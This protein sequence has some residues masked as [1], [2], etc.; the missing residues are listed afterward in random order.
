MI[1][2]NHGTAA[3]HPPADPGIQHHRRPFIVIAPE[4]ATIVSRIQNALGCSKD[5]AT[6]YAKA[7]GENPEIVHGKILLRNE[8]N[9]IVAYVPAT[10]LEVTA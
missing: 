5:M 1:R 7:I 2:C 6:E 8:Q 3:D 10:V 9:R 4:L